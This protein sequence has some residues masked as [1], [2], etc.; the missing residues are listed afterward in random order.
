MTNGMTTRFQ[1]GYSWWR[2]QLWRI[3]LIRLI[4]LFSIIS[5]SNSISC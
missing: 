1:W 3:Q 5:I 2:I 4:I